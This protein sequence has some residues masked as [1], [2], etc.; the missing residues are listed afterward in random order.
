MENEDKK[1]LLDRERQG[2][3]QK[4]L[5]RCYGKAF[6]LNLKKATMERLVS[7]IP[8][9]TR[10]N[11]ESIT[12]QRSLAVTELINWYYLDNNVARNTANSAAAYDVYCKIR[13]MRLAG[14]ITHAIATELTDAGE[15]IPVFDSVTGRL[16][17]EE[18]VWSSRDVITLS[19]TDKVIKMI[20]SNEQ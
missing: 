11:E 14:K 13:D 7:L 20:E 6:S 3:R 18:G 17:L 16:S 19:N 2:K 12:I 10:T 4:S 15:V 1:R 8:V 5:K 9:V